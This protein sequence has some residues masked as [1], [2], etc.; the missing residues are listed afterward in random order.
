[1]DLPIGVFWELSNCVPR[2]Q[3]DRDIRALTV[4]AHAQSSEGQ[5]TL[6]DELMKVVGEPLKVSARIPEKRD[7]EGFARLKQMAGGL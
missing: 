3:A 7:E 4:A 2:L 1:M 6:R 5:K